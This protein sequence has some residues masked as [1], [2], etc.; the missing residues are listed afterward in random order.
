MSKNSLIALLGKVEVMAHRLNGTQGEWVKRRLLAGERLIHTDLIDA[1]NG[2][3]GWRLGAHIHRLR[4][5]GWPIRATALPTQNENGFGAPVAYSLPP[6]W[7]P[8]SSEQ[9][10]LTL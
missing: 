3:G 1:C 9:L 7:R 10:E 5:E 4:V 6:G 2:R 8:G